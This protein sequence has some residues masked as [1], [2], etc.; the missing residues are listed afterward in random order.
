VFFIFCLKTADD[1]SD[2]CPH[3]LDPEGGVSDLDFD[4]ESHSLSSSNYG[5]YLNIGSF[6]QMQVRVLVQFD[7]LVKNFF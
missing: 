1:D 4:R 5:S 2:S 6:T 3:D 7:Y